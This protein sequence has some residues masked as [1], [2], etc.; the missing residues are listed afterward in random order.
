MNIFRTL[1]KTEGSFSILSNGDIYSW[2]SALAGNIFW[3][4]YKLYLSMDMQSVFQ[5]GRNIYK[6]SRSMNKENIQH[7][8]SMTF[9]EE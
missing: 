7:Q 9:T 1:M 3:F 5:T 2:K 4:A 8:K 6:M